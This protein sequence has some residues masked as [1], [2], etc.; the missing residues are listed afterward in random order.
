[1]AKFPTKQQELGQFFTPKHIVNFI[2]DNVSLKRKNTIADISCGDGKFLSYAFNKIKKLTQ[3]EI[4]TV[5]QIYGIELSDSVL[6]TAHERILRQ[7]ESKKSELILL[8]NLVSMNT[9]TSSVKEIL[10]KFPSIK[11][12]DGFDIIV[13][14]PPYV[15]LAVADNHLREDPSYSQIICGQVNLAT[16]IIVRAFSLLKNNGRLGLL[17]PKSLFR[18]ESYQ[19]LRDFLMSN[20]EIDYLVDVGA[21]FK[22]VRGEQVIFI[23]RKN[24]NPSNKSIRVGLWKKDEL[25]PSL[26]DIPKKNLIRFGIFQL[27]DNIKV[28]S[29]VSKII[30]RHQNLESICNG[31]IYRGISIGANS[32]CVSPIQ[33]KH[34]RT[35]IRGDSIRK[36]GYKYLIYLKNQNYPKPTDEVQSKKIVAQNIF[37]S[38]SGIVATYDDVGLIPLNTITNIFPL[39]EDPYYVLGI[40]NS[41]LARLFMVFVIFAKARLTMHTDR[42]YIGLIPIPKID[43]KLKNSIIKQVKSSLNG[44][45]SD[46]LNS[47]VCSAFKLSSKEEQLIEDELIRFGKDGKKNI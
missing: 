22:E 6:Q 46:T 27:Y 37:S 40:L 33:K 19:K 14:N 45:H 18:V 24:K 13:G 31:K 38:E 15:T 43:S 32:S 10:D 9:I 3:D 34:Y 7:C 29:L 36:F 42:H 2:L 16:L 12:D 20:F 28:H 41:K 1:M 25:T 8:N 17:L 21:G 30:G 5:S 23:G 44:V 35:A 4:S 47:L 26:T 39:N 11:Q